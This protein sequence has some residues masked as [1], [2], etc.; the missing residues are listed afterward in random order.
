MMRS[1][2]LWGVLFLVGA[3]GLYMVK[4]KVQAIRTEVA[5][6]EKQ[7]REEKKNLHVLDAEWTYLNRPDR[8]RQLSA[9]YLDVKP[10]HAQQIA[11]FASFPYSQRTAA[12]QQANEREDEAPQTD[13]LTLA[14]G[15]AHVR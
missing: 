2:I 4:Y 15:V 6:T 3:L 14:S 11:D 5:V 7:L 8:L 12:S 10:A 13:G 9:K 1:T